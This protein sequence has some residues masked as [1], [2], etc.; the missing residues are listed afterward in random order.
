VKYWIDLATVAD[1][2]FPRMTRT[3]TRTASKV[4]EASLTQAARRI[5]AVEVEGIFQL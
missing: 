2:L 5:S 1:I 3:I 4:A